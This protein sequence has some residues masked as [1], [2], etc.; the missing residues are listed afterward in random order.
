MLMTDGDG[1][2]PVLHGAAIGGKCRTGFS[3][4]NARLTRPQIVHRHVRQRAHGK[5]MI[6][7]FFR[8]AQWPAGNRMEIPCAALE[9][10]RL[11]WSPTLWPNERVL[12]VEAAHALT[13]APLGLAPC[14]KGLQSGHRN[15][16]R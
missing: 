4:S 5:Q 2:K 12:R 16:G 14:S 9:G 15:S 8:H 7:L 11:T 10:A 13:W 6:N 3:P 1:L